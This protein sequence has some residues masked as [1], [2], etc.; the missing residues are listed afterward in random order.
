M[1]WAGSGDSVKIYVEGVD[2]DKEGAEEALTAG[3]ITE[4]TKVEFEKLV[5]VIRQVA[6]EATGGLAALTTKPSEI[7]LEFGLTLGVKGGFPVFA[8]VSG[9]G[10]ITVG[11]VW[12]YDK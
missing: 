1:S 2:L 5:G 10:S 8:E 12:R 7:S 9:E 11:L 3:E 4:K 6:D